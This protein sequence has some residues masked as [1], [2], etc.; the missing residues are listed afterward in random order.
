VTS[1]PEGGLWLVDTETRHVRHLG[2]DGT[3]IDRY[4]IGRGLNADDV[5]ALRMGPDGTLWAADDARHRVL[6]LV[7]G[8]P[9]ADAR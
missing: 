9:D 2:P 7:P 5:A 3:E 1:D 8:A 4:P 6:R